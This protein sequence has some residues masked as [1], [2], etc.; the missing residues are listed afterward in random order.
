MKQTYPRYLLHTFLTSAV[1]RILWS[2]LRLRGR[3]P[4]Y[5][6]YRKTGGSPRRSG[7][8][9]KEKILVTLGGNRSPIPRSPRPQPGHCVYLG[10]VLFTPSEN[11]RIFRE[12]ISDIIMVVLSVGWVLNS[13]P[14]SS[15]NIPRSKNI[16]NESYSGMWDTLPSKWFIRSSYCIRDNE[17]NWACEMELLSYA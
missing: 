12:S 8:R 9:Y 5:Q 1:C 6:F 16:P 4:Q 15:L 14:E 7:C 10:A 3:S 17:T 2:A 13:V 11:C